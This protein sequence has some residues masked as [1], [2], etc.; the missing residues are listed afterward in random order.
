VG[1]HANDIDG[2]KRLFHN[3]VRPFTDDRHARQPR[4]WAVL[5]APWVLVQEVLKELDS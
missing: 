3:G 5:V 1:V 4:F 2:C